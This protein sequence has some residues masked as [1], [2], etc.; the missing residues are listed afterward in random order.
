M[1]C[2]NCGAQLQDG[3][4][5]CTN[6]GCKLEAPAPQPAQPQYQ[7]PVYQQPVYQQAAP[8][9]AEQP[10]TLVWGILSLVFTEIGI[11][12]LIFAIIGRSKGNSFI[13][14]GGQ[15]TGASKVGFILSK[16]GLILSIVS[17]V[18][19]VLFIILV[20]TGSAAFSSLF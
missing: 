11:L 12:G 9:Y 20:A 1:I 16:V 10:S 6:C 17:L 14:T 2:K 5:F 19:W 8:V 7:Q 3:M 18:F 4:A 13:S 15:L